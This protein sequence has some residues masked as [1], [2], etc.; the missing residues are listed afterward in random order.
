MLYCRSSGL[1]VFGQGNNYKG[2]E[3]KELR[4]LLLDG[5][6][7]Y[8]FRVCLSFACKEGWW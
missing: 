3:E 2:R 4:V 6:R 1:G 5:K 7:K 8:T